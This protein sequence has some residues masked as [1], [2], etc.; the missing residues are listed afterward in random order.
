VRLLA[1]LNGL[2]GVR[3]FRVVYFWKTGNPQSSFMDRNRSCGGEVFPDF[4]CG[5][6]RRSFPNGVCDHGEPPVGCC[7][8]GS[9]FASTSTIPVRALFLIIL[10]CNRGGWRVRLALLLSLIGVFQTELAAFRLGT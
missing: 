3:V 9:S 5:I 8:G 2:F 1:I 6:R 7:E 10:Q 4:H